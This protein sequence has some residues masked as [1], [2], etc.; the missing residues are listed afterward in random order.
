MSVWIKKT[1][2]FGNPSD[3]QDKVEALQLQV[4]PAT[5]WL[6]VSTDQDFKTTT[7]FIRLPDEIY[8]DLFAGFDHCI[9]TDLPVRATL[10]VGANSEFEA[11]FDYPAAA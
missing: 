4:K 3:V 7:F 11:L 6:L 9:D 2:P 10:L 8:L 1:I 5:A